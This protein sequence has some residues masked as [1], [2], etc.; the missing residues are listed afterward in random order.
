MTQPRRPDELALFREMRAAPDILSGS[1]LPCGC[2]SPGRQKVED[3]ARTIGI[4]EKRVSYILEKW[5]GKGWWEYGVN[6]WCG[7]FTEQAPEELKP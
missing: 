3:I 4:P 5:S 7:W 2:T 6:V 1:P